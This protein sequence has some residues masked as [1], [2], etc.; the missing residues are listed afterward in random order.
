MKR[1]I[2]LA[3][4]LAVGVAA[5]GWRGRFDE[6]FAAATSTARL[7][8]EY[9]EVEYLESTGTQWIDTGLSII[10]NRWTIDVEFKERGDIGTQRDGSARIGF[11]GAGLH[12]QVNLGSSYAIKPDAYIRRVSVLDDIMG[13]KVDVNDASFTSLPGARPTTSLFLFGSNG[14]GKAKCLIFSSFIEPTGGGTY[15]QQF[16]P[17]VRKA[18]SVAGMYDLVSK[19]FFTNQGTGEFIVGPPVVAP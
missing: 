7:P 2:L 8:A 14:G 5:A 3:V 13:V 15:I 19:Q 9:Q 4:V 11:A 10:G 6:Q 18:D 12:R 16:I 1:L 17:A